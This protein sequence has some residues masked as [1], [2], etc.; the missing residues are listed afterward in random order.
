M[1]KLYDVIIIGGGPAGLSAAM[2]AGRAR[3]S[4]LLIE[5]D[6]YGGQIVITSEIENYPGGMGHESGADLI[7]RMVAQ[8]DRFGADKV[9]DTIIDVDLESDT[10]IVKGQK[11]EYRGKTVIIATGAQPRPIGCPGERELISK[12]VSYCATC[13]ANFFED[14][15]VFVVGG[16]DSAVE[17]AI[18]LA[19][20]A[21]KVTIIHRRDALRAA[22]SIQ[23]RAFANPKI[24]YMWDSVV[25]EL[26]GDGILTSMV[27]QNVK[28]N[29]TREIFADEEDGTFGVFVFVGFLPNSKVFEGKVAMQ[30]NYIIAD[31][32]MHTNVHG[33]YVAGDIRIKKLRQVV[34]AAADG[35][36]AAIE[37]EKFL[38]E[39]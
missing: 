30:D 21:R 22:K 13:D 25:V 2:Y 35:A 24:D 27:V 15:E 23:E 3:L 8:V 6:A 39:G 5:K 16:G 14:F 34:T 17:E 29:E 1:D 37:A 26:K 11:G 20:F 28:T 7:K 33:V 18:Y 19:K 12:G 38:E 31:E 32:N 36:I 4:T 9:T 10:K